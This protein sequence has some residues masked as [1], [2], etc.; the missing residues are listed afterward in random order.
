MLIDLNVF[1]VPCVIN[2]I[3]IL[4]CKQIITDLL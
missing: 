3:N 1:K 4:K 2:I